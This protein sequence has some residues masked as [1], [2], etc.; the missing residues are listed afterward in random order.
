MITKE[1]VWERNPK[2][3]DYT[4]EYGEFVPLQISAH[5]LSEKTKP[6]TV[7]AEREQ[8][9]LNYLKGNT[10]VYS[11]I[12]VLHPMGDEEEDPAN[13]LV[14]LDGRHTV[15]ALETKFDDTPITILVPQQEYRQIAA[16]L[17]REE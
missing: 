4:E 9:V 10:K 14:F 2:A 13:D 12:L 3:D 7:S 8:K 11:P 5:K 6:S 15:N 17:N 1:F 16:L